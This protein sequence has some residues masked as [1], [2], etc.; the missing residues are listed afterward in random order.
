MKEKACGT[1][2]VDGK[3]AVVTGGTRGI[4]LAIAT[5]LCEAGAAVTLNYRANREAAEQVK[6]KLTGRFDHQVV[7]SDVSTHEGARKL[8]RATVEKWGRVDILV[9]NSGV[10]DFCFIEEMDEEFFDRMYRDNLKSIFFTTREVIPEMKKRNFGRI[11]NASSIS[12][13]LA[14]CGLSAYGCSKAGVDMF[15]L[16]SSAELAPYGITVNAYSP[17]IVETD[18]TRPMIRERGKEQVKQIPLGRFGTP[19]DV[20]ALVCFLC[21]DQAGYITGEIIGV[22]GGMFKVQNPYRAWQR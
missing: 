21:S 12:S 6:K 9:N 10:F 11:I 2:S 7:Q 3:V 16:I 17:G 13:H 15:T 4:G 1:F 18:M 19:E 5:A 14:D 20:A 8:V 22:D